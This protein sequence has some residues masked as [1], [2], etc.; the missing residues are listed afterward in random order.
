M[1]SKRA[2]LSGIQDENVEPRTRRF[3]EPEN[4]AK[5]VSKDEKDRF[6]PTP[7]PSG[8]EFLRDEKK[9]DMKTAHIR[10]GRQFLMLI[11]NLLQTSKRSKDC[12][13][14]RK[15]CFA[16]SRNAQNS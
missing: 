14:A 4:P 9:I 2:F 15:E 12:K 10:F 13:Q 7:V 11:K 1:A 5:K 8:K 3:E 6:G 16:K